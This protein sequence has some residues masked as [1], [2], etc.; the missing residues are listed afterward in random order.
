MKSRERASQR[1]F[2]ILVGCQLFSSFVEVRS[3]A[4][5]TSEGDTGS[6]QGGRTSSLVFFDQ[7]IDRLS[8]DHALESTRLMEADST[9]KRFLITSNKDLK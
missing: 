9:L 2:N 8:S 7:C 3:L 6:G 4:S 1:V 5:F